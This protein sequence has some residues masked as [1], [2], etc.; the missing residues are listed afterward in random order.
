MFTSL[1]LAGT[2]AIGQP[3]AQGQAPIGMQA[4][5]T[6]YTGAGFS[7]NQPFR[8]Q[9][10]VVGQTPTTYTGAGFSPNQPF[11]S[12]SPVVGQTPATSYTLGGFTL[13]Q[14][15]TPVSNPGLGALNTGLPQLQPAR[16]GAG[17]T[18]DQAPAG[19][20]GKGDGKD[21]E[22]EPDKKPFGLAPDWKLEDEKSTLMR[23]IPLTTISFSHPRSRHP[24]SQKSLGPRFLLPGHH[25][26]S[27]ATSIRGTRSLAFPRT[28]EPFHS[29]KHYMAVHLG[30][31][32]K[33][34]KSLLKVG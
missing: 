23:S 29:C 8:S 27:R 32:S 30:R 2:L 7:P 5:A 15:A 16:Y 19:Q 22:K 17:A 14:N 1:V 6:T 25:R 4:P 10:P 26:R 20:N 11:Q 24:K 28:L 13:S 18:P 3:P 12:Q 34:A 33:I 21:A 31:K 9:S